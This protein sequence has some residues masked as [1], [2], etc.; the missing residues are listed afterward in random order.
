MMLLTTLI[1]NGKNKMLTYRLWIPFDYSAPVVYAVIFAL[2]AV[3]VIISSL[4]NV[5]YDGL[6]S[7][8]MFCIHSQLEILG[9]RLQNVVK[10]GKESAKE[11]ARHHNFLYE[12]VCSF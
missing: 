1:T 7:G 8:L 6:F 11:C 2:Q 4:M 12:Y 3:S 9:L 5:T 10:N